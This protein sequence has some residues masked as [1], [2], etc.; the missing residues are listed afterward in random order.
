MFKAVTRTNG[1]SGRRACERPI[2]A[3]V[4]N[5]TTAAVVDL[6]DLLVEKKNR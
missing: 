2:V 1:H 5:R 4:A 6:T 3:H